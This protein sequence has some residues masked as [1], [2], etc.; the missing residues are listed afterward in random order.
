LRFDE[1]Y[2]AGLEDFARKEAFVETN[3]LTEKVDDF[4]KVKPVT[5]MQP[6]A[7]LNVDA[8]A[9]AATARAASKAFIGMKELQDGTVSYEHVAES[10]THVTSEGAVSRFGWNKASVTL[11]ASAVASDG[12]E[13]RG[14]LRFTGTASTDLPSADALKE[15]AKALGA[16]VSAISKLKPAEEDYAG[17]VL[18]TGQAAALFFAQTIAEPLGRPRLPLGTNSSGRLVE[19]VGKHVASKLV[20]VFDDPTLKSVS[21]AGKSVPLWG[22]FPVDDDGVLSQKVSL[23]EAGVLKTYFMSRVPTAK[24][25]ETN[26]HCRGDQGAA[27]NMFVE[28]AEK[29]P[30][31]AMKKRLV[32]LAKE[33]D[34]DFGLLV[35][36][37]EEYV[38]RSWGNE[39]QRLSAPLVVY[40]V[41]ADGRE[42]LVRGLVFKPASQR[43]LKDIVAMGDDTTVLNLELRGQST[44]IIAPSVLVKLMELA[45]TKDENEKPPALPR[46]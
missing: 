37:A 44:S 15:E 1:A 2:K 10:Q 40:K 24:V 32:E 28:T 38:P 11:I 8:E 3:R 26:G 22:Y 27:G 34:S 41:F 43:V 30:L 18:F 7:T 39:G 14:T 42:E 13:V 36:Q 17:P 46:P 33:E 35:A 9:L 6:K 20:S 25:K 29:T 12:A 5:L 31:A 19:R 23:I 16:R 21:V 45:R 4:S